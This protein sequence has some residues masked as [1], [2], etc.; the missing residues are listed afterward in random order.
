MSFSQRRQHEQECEH[1]GGH[2]AERPQCHHNDSAADYFCRFELEAR[3][4]AF[5]KLALS[6][7]RSRLL[8]RVRHGCLI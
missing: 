5:V 8:A 7:L 1:D 2:R 3:C 6:A 4:L